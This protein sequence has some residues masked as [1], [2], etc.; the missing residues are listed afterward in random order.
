M[1][2]DTLN[3]LIGFGYDSHT[4]HLIAIQAHK[5]GLTPDDVTAWIAEATYSGTIRNPRGFVRAAITRGDK[6]PA[7]EASRSHHFPETNYL[8]PAL[9]PNCQAR[10]CLCDWDSETETLSEFRERTIPGIG[11]T[12]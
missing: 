4:A 9:C 12:T 11:G 6:P 10:P 1:H 3:L 5:H 8:S 7:P 2:T